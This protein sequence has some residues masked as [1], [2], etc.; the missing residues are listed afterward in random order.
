MMNLIEDKRTNW[1]INR[2]IGFIIRKFEKN[3]TINIKSC[4]IKVGDVLICGK[5]EWIPADGIL[6]HTNEPNGS[7]YVRTD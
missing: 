2:Y 4:D 7:I 1:S 5:G 6:L 3:R